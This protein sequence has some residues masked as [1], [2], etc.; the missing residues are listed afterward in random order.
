M[1]RRPNRFSEISLAQPETLQANFAPPAPMQI[2]TPPMQMPDTS[3]QIAGLGESLMGI[4]K[5]QGMQNHQK[6]AILSALAEKGGP[7]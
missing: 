5:R 3:G 1:M 2:E 4:K 7:D 6:D